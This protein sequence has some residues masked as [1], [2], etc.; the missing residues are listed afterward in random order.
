MERYSL[1]DQA[2]EAAGNVTVP[3]LEAPLTFDDVQVYEVEGPSGEALL[4]SF[5]LVPLLTWL[6]VVNAY[7]VEYTDEVD[8]WD[9]TD[10]DKVVDAL[11][12]LHYDRVSY[13]AD[14]EVEF[15]WNTRGVT[16]ITVWVVAPEGIARVPAQ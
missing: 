2:R 14:G 13:I 6:K 7:H 11:S 15:L 9:P 8:P 4:V 3:D 16:P 1:A 12:R 10:P 5:G